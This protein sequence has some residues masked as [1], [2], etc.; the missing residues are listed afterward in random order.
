LKTPNHGLSNRENFVRAFAKTVIAEFLA[1]HDV[2]LVGGTVAGA[3]KLASSNF[4]ALLVDCDLPDGKGT[5]VMRALRAIGFRGNIVGVSAHEEGNSELRV[6]GAS[7]TCAKSSF[8]IIAA[9]L[10]STFR[11]A[12][13]KSPFV[14]LSGLDEYPKQSNICLIKMGHQRRQT[15]LDLQFPTWGGRRE[16]AGRKGTPGRRPCVPHRP[17]GEHK[18]RHPVHVTLRARGGLPPFRENAL[19]GAMREA[20]RAASRSPGVGDAFRVVHFSVQ[21]DHVHLIIEAGGRDA[22]IRGV[23]G[24]AIRLA[25]AVNRTLGLPGSV[26]S[27]RY[28]SRALKTPREVRHAIVYVLMNAKKHGRTLVRGVDTYSSAPWFDGFHGSESPLDESSPV[29]RPRT[30]LAGAGWRRRGLVRPDEKPS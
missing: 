22:L 30:W 9:A 25:R 2:T 8:R 27:D 15:Q 29:M 1:H 19:F 21:R 24:L 23:Q 11:S 26:W 4:D 7:T 18:A 14:A 5:E 17:R 6:A 12:R 20:I 28:H 16:G 13:L 3:K 10:A